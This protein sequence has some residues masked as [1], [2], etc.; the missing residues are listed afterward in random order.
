MWDEY[1]AIA[2]R[3]YSQTGASTYR[4]LVEAGAEWVYSTADLVG[5]VV[6]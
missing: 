4:Q 2:S 5:R 6:S 1:A 3:D